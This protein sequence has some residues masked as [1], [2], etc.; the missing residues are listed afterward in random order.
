[1][2][3]P[4]TR[5]NDNPETEH[6]ARIGEL[7]K[8]YHH[9]GN[10]AFWSLVKVLER[11]FSWSGLRKFDDSLAHIAQKKARTPLLMTGKPRHEASPGLI[12]YVCRRPASQC[13]VKR[14]L[15]LLDVHGSNGPDC[16]HAVVLKTCV[17][18]NT[19]TNAFVSPLSLALAG[20]HFH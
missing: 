11:N 4:T 3:S 14:E 5:A 6:V 16:I 2:P 10:C 13:T 15:S 12:Y 17:R 20:F 19:C 9:S 18:T 8:S 7:V 1:M